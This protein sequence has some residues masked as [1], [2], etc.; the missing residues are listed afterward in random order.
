M[1]EENQ[2]FGLICL[3]FNF[4]FIMDFFFLH[5]CLFLF[6]AMPPGMW[7]LSSLTRDLTHAPCSGGTDS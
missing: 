6:L 1:K 4:L 2:V 3:I 5:Q 7:D